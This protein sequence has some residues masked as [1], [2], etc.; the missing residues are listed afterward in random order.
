MCKALKVSRAG[1]YRWMSMNSFQGS[2]KKEALSEQIKD[3]YEDSRRTYGSPR[4]HAILLRSKVNV[5]RSTVSRIMKKLGLY[6]EIRKKWKPRKKRKNNSNLAKNLLNRDFNP[7]TKDHS[8]AGDITYIWT[9]QGWVYLSVILDLFS[10][11]LIGW[12]LEKHM[13]ASLVTSTFVTAFMNRRPESTIT[14]HSDPGVQYQSGSF[15]KLLAALDIKQSMNNP[16]E[17]YD[18]A[19]ME[20]FF[21]TIKVELLYR[22]R[23]QDLESTRSLI[24]EWIECFYNRKRIHS[25]LGFLSPEEYEL[26][27]A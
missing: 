25:T 18:N 21:K 12:R 9:S 22:T 19:A 4:V 3:I 10:R 5:S 1:Y 8:W 13:E 24:F 26:K 20:S 15:S 11:K 27:Y 17:C 2:T 14:F 16:G 7:S 23:L 6:S